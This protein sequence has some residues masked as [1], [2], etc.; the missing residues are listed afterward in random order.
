M[1]FNA[2]IRAK[3]YQPLYTN[4]TNYY[5]YICLL[6]KYNFFLKLISFTGVARLS[7]V[8][9]VRLLV[10]SFNERNSFFKILILKDSSLK[11]RGRKESRQVSVALIGWATHVL[12][13]KL[14]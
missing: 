2:I 4:E 1:W 7:S 3:P 13:W 6:E 8:R 14:Q 9:V 5:Y 10:N 11:M 12:Q